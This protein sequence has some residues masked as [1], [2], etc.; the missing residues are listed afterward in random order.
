MISGAIEVNLF[1]LI[2]L[3]LKARFGEDLLTNNVK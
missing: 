2:C 1:A 3:I